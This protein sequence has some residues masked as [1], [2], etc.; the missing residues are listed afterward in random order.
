[1][2]VREMMH[3]L[4]STGGRFSAEDFRQRYVKFMTTPGSHNDTYAS[5]CH[6]MFFEKWRS[7]GATAE[8]PDNDGHNVDTIDGLVLPSV[9]ALA[10]LARGE[11]V[12]EATRQ[13]T[14]ALAVTRA[15]SVPQPH[16]T[17]W[18]GG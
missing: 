11:S 7:G 12:E 10:T 9:V 8:C 14:E 13:A 1:M 15:S 17:S 6:R 2:L 16:E 18:H 5:T 3:S 4:T